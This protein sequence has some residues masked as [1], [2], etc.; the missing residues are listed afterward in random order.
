MT[1]NLTPAPLAPARVVW[2][3]PGVSSVVL[4]LSAADTAA[5][6]PHHTGRIVLFGI[7]YTP[8]V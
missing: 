4:T 5:L 6:D 7:T 8:E 1:T 3:A 2:R